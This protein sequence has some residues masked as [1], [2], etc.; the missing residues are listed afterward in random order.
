MPTKVFLSYSHD[1]E[2]HSQRVLALANQ[3]RTHGVDAE[4]DQYVTRPAQGWPLWCE[5]QLRPEISEFVLV[6][7]TE[8]YRNR[9][10]R[11]V[12]ADEGR[13]VYWEGGLIYNYLYDQKGQTDRA[14]V[15]WQSAD[16]RFQL[17]LI[18][19]RHQ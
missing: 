9:I 7:C 16:H 6:I 4:L 2:A 17:S 19:E 1:S 18:A 11:K 10:E 14:A 15:L 3:L 12:P 5:E 13:G 8:T